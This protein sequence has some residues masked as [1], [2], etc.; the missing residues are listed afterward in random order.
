VIRDARQMRNFGPGN[1]ENASCAI[2]H[3]MFAVAGA[4]E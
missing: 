2:A 4:P 3:L 1:L